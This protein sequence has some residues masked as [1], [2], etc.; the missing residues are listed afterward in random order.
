MRHSIVADVPL[1]CESNVFAT[2]SFRHGFAFAALESFSGQPLRALC[3]IGHVL[4]V[5]DGSTLHNQPRPLAFRQQLSAITSEFGW[6]C[7]R[8]EAQ[9]ITGSTAMSLSRR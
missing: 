7:R 3:Y 5:L 8:R 1:G 2:A 4:E 6:W 9:E